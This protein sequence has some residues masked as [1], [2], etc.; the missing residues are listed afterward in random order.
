[1]CGADNKALVNLMNLYCNSR[2]LCCKSN[3]F[4]FI[5]VDFEFYVR[6]IVRT[7]SY[8]DLNL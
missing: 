4:T 1:M 8:C 7:P 5:I 6:K 2:A 3:Y